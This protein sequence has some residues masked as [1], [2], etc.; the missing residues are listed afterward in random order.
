MN[1]LHANLLAVQK[2]CS[3]PD[4]VKSLNNLSENI[5]RNVEQL[6]KIE[7]EIRDGEHDSKIIDNLVAEYTEITSPDKLRIQSSSEIENLQS[8]LNGLRKSV[9]KAQPGLITKAGA[10]E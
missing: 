8:E 3:S 10:E 6:R 5:Q 2:V 1:S 7:D 9:K 4:I